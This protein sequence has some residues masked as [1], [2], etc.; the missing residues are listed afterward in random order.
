M[1]NAVAFG[2]A[3]GFVVAG[4]AMMLGLDPGGLIAGGIIW[5]C[6]ALIR[7]AGNGSQ[8]E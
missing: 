3:C 7:G 4:I 2:V 5:G 1:D 6:V 8:G